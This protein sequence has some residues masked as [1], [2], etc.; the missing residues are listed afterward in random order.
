MTL[1]K[2][3]WM[4]PGLVLACGLIIGIAFMDQ[5]HH[6]SNDLPAM[7]GTIH[8]LIL[9]TDFPTS[10]ASISIYKITSLEK[11]VQ[12]ND[13]T[14]FTVKKSIPSATEAPA[15]AEKVLER[16]GGLPKEAQLL[17][18]TPRYI[19]KF[20]L[21][22][23]SIEEKKPISTQVRYIQMLNGSPVI[24]AG[25]NLNLGEDGEIIDIMKIWP[26]YEYS[27]EVNV[28]TAERGFEKLKNHETTDKLQGDL[29][30]G[31]KIT[32]IKLGYKLYRIEPDVEESYLKPV[33]IYY[34]IT[35]LDP[36]PFPLMVDATA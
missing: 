28:I 6:E 17:E 16:Y 34:A 36:E 29:P 24:G 18:A 1:K 7:Q 13:K 35:P 8:P 31:T 22:T 3:Y 14:A 2:F 23:N 32:D 11:T 26:S 10:P 27:G 30:E 12:G 25:I 4:V 5:M 15:I 21:T 20:N 33:W 9:D 19:N